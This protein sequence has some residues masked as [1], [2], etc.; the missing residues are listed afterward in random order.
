MPCILKQYI[1]SLKEPIMKYNDLVN[2]ITAQ[3]SA[4]NGFRVVPYISGQPGGGKSAC[5]REIARKLQ[6][7]LGIPD[8]RVVEFNPSLRDPVDILGIPD[9]KGDCA[10]WLPPEEFYAIRSGVGPAILILEELSDAT[11]AMQ[12]PLCRVILDRYAGQMKLSEELYI[13]ATGNRTEDRSGAN[14]LSTKLGNRMRQYKFDTSLDDWVAWAVKHEVRPE[15]IGFLR[16]RPGLLHDFDP[17]RTVNPTPRS[18]EDVSLIPTDV[19]PALYYESVCGAVGEGAAAEYTA[20]LRVFNQLPDV[21]EFLK[22]PSSVQTSKD[23]SVIYALCAKLTSVVTKR[24][25]PKFYKWL[26]TQ[27][28]EFM[29]MA[30][31]DMMKACPSIYSTKEFMDFATKNQQLLLGEA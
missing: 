23:P 18:W 26:E 21:E 8:E 22:D 11:M 15:L 24:N 31:R 27:P 9:T 10:H 19:A 7:K 6:A 1:L 28:K 25:F 29:V 2:I 17:K 16:F 5:V 20:F 13:L 14:R 4:K 12:N 30:I 3:F